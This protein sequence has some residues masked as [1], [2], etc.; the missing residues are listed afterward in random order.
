MSGVFLSSLV[1]C[2]ITALVIAVTGVL[3]KVGADGKALNGARLVMEAFHTVIP[4]GDLR[5]H[6]LD[7]IRL[8]DD[9][10]LGL[11][12][13]EVHGIFG[14]TKSPSRISRCFLPL[15]LYGSCDEF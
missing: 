12:R 6:L 11:L 9:G 15:C 8:H 13:R 5:D 14:R 4:G 3:G 1:V 7:P 2:S 10:R